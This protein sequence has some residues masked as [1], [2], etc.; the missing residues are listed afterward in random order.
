MLSVAGADHIITMDLHASQIQ[1]FFDIPVD[2]LYAEP[3]VLKWIR[4]NTSEWRNCTVVSP[5]AEGAKRVTSIA[6]RLNVDFALIHKER[7]K[8]NEVDR[9]VLVGDV[10]DRVPSSWMTW[11]TLVA[12]SDMQ[13]TNFSPL[14]PP[15]FMLS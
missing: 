12:Q 1:G 8:A 14:E 15:G 11:L 9:V 5:D 6:D 10:K 13:L 3:A 7:K 4:E 2:N